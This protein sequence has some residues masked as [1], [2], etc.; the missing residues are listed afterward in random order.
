MFS[1]QGG[2][3]VVQLLL[4]YDMSDVSSNIGALL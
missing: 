3:K 1:H 2:I 4:Q